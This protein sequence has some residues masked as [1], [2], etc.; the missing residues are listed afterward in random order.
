LKG[1]K[2]LV[3][4]LRILTSLNVQSKLNLCLIN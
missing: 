2:L 4:I 1:M 3:S